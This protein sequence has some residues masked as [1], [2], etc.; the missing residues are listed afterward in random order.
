MTKLNGVSKQINGLVVATR[1]ASGGNE[2]RTTRLRLGNLNAG[3]RAREVKTRRD[4]ARRK[5]VGRGEG[6]RV[7][8]FVRYGRGG[9]ERE[10]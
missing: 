7:D 5:S 4:E 6:L 3:G 2:I 8:V 9:G 10:G 1:N